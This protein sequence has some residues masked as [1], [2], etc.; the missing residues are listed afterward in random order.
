MS[1]GARTVGAGVALALLGTVVGCGPDRSP[2]DSSED[3]RWMAECEAGTCVTVVDDNGGPL[4][5]YVEPRGTN[6]G[7]AAIFCSFG[8]R[9]PWLLPTDAPQRS[10]EI[11]HAG[12]VFFMPDGQR[13]KVERC[14]YELDYWRGYR[15]T[16]AVL[17]FEP[18]KT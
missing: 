12:G 3:A 11:F 16:V 13:V 10:K 8:F 4:A 5:V 6:G 15:H 14:Y 7:D 1:R 17:L 18:K 9:P 2:P